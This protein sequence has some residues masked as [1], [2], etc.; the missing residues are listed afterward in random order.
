MLATIHCLVL[1]K[2]GAKNCLSM[3][4]IL[5]ALEMAWLYRLINTLRAVLRQKAGFTETGVPIIVD[6]SLG[7]NPNRVASALRARGFNA[8]SVTELFGPD[9]GDLA[10]RQLANVLGG[11][12]VASDRGRDL[13]GG[14]GRTTLRVHG[15]IRSVD[16][17]I[18]IVEGEIG[19]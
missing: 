17:V 13:M 3:G 10:I 2:Q 7:I 16:S 4:R 11:R 19:R 9:P 8:H 12:V 15:R 1:Q 5:T 6:N 18:R 14:F